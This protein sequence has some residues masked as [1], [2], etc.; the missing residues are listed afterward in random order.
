MRLVSS[1][2]SYRAKWTSTDK[3]SE[4]YPISDFKYSL[5][6][7]KGF[8]LANPMLSGPLANLLLQ[9]K[10]WEYKVD[11]YNYLDSDK[12]ALACLRTS[13]VQRRG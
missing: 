11:D 2:L 9:L 5:C 4:F 13:F 1:K 10:A 12:P 8:Y 3:D 7:L 6:S